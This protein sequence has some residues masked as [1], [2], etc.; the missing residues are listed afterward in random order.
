MTCK[1]SLHWPVT[2]CLSPFLKP[3]R[4]ENLLILK[5]LFPSWVALTI[6][7]T[8]A[9]SVKFF[10]PLNQNWLLD[11][12]FLAC[13]E[14]PGTRAGPLSFDHLFSPLPPS[15][16]LRTFILGFGSRGPSQVILH[17]MWKSPHKHFPHSL[18]GT[19]LREPISFC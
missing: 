3:S 6:A 10:L 13:L 7:L 8:V 19:L 4:A 1:S 2:C 17:I 5:Q 14:W 12:P 15:L 18:L 16:S 11:F 9:L